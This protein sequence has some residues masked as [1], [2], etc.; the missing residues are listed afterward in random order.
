MRALLQAHH[1]GTERLIIP[2]QPLIL[3]AQHADR[4]Q[5]LARLEQALM[6]MRLRARGCPK[7]SARKGRDRSR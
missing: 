3:G 6:P 1:A 2:R 5:Q 7:G 4:L